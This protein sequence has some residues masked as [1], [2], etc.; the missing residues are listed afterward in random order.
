MDRKQG[1]FPRQPNGPTL[2]LPSNYE[3]TESLKAQGDIL[4]DRKKLSGDRNGYNPIIAD[5]IIAEPYAVGRRFTVCPDD[6][7]NRFT[8]E[9]SLIH[10]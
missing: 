8:V 2:R 5:D 4:A 1:I 10:I 9:L 3:H 7:Y 6:P